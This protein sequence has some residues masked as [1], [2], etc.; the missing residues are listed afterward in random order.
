VAREVVAQLAGGEVP[1][2][3]K[4]VPVSY[5][6]SDLNTPTLSFSQHVVMFSTS[7][8]VRT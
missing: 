4:L 2:L 1:H 5:G 8:D 6:K 3:D 7:R